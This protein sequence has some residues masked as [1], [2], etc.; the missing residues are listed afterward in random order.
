MAQIEKGA[1]EFGYQLSEK[2]RLSSREELDEAF[3]ALDEQIAQRRRAAGRRAAAQG[4]L[5]GA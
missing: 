1:L 2:G 4:R 5:S 3:T